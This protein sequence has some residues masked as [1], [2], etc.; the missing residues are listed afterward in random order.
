M[1]PGED[2]KIVELGSEEGKTKI[3]SRWL[4]RGVGVEDRLGNCTKKWEKA[5]A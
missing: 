2:R 3:H 4:E 5:S 1:W